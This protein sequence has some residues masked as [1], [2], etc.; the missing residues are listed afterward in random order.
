MDI[1]NT[2]KICMR[3]K[4]TVQV[5]GKILKNSQIIIKIL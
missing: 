2:Y 1:Y 4:N 3:V 5:F